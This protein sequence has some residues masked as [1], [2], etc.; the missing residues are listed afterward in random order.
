MFQKTKLKLPILVYKLLST[1]TLPPPAPSQRQCVWIDLTLTSFNN[2]LEIRKTFNLGELDN[3][4]TKGVRSHASHITIPTLPQWP[5]W[6]AR[7]KPSWENFS[8]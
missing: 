5:Q 2:W 1:N 8:N 4:V 3:N 7:A 6:G